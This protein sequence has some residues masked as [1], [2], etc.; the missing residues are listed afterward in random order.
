MTFERAARI[1]GGSLFAE[2]VVKWFSQV[3]VH[4]HLAA[5]TSRGAGGIVPASN[6]DVTAVFVVCTGRE[7][8]VLCSGL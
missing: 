4:T 8:P 5:L 2:W 1:V 6:R 3:L 7:S